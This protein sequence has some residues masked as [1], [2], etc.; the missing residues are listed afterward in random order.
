MSASSFARRSSKHAM[1]DKDQDLA[2]SMLVPARVQAWAQAPA[3]AS[4]TKAGMTV[5][6]R[7]WR[8]VRVRESRSMDVSKRHCEGHWKEPLEP[9]EPRQGLSPKFEYGS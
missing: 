7:P 9:C 1:W 3:W 5:E 6:Y 4:Q 8:R 2:V